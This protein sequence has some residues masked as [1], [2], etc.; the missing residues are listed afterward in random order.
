MVLVELFFPPDIEAEFLNTTAY[1]ENALVL[2][3]LFS[4]VLLVSEEKRSARHLAC[5]TEDDPIF[6][7]GIVTFYQSAAKESEPS[8]CENRNV[9]CSTRQVAR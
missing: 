4:L 8:G 9:L 7:S 6:T 3:Y 1:L 2:E 5:A